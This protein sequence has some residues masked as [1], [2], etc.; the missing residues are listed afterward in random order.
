V[1]IENGHVDRLVLDARLETLGPQ[2][3]SL[4]NAGA[5]WAGAGRCY[6]LPNSR[7]FWQRSDITPFGY[8]A[9][10]FR[11]VA[12]GNAARKHQFLPETPVGCAFI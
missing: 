8:G 10:Y 11:I 1:A 9:A 12:V 3:D 6:R 5:C 4:G 2:G 7:G